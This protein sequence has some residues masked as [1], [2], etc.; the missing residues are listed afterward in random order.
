[1]KVHFLKF[2]RV[3]QFPIFIF[4]REMLRLLHTF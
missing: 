1:M 2:I 4:K 3:L